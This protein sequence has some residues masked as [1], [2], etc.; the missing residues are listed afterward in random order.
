METFQFML[1]TQGLGLGQKMSL[2]LLLILAFAFVLDYWEQRS[3]VDMNFCDPF[4][5][6]KW[7]Q[8]VC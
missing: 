3:V 2:T 6:S 5:D 7:N 4:C 1:C 8:F